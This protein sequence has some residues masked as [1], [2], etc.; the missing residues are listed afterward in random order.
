VVQSNGTVTE[1]L[2]N[3]GWYVAVGVPMGRWLDPA[4]SEARAGAMIRRG[5]Q[6]AIVEL[7]ALSVFLAALTPKRWSEL[8]TAAVEAGVEDP[9]ALVDSLQSDGLLIHFDEDEQ[10]NLEALRRLRLQPIGVG[11]GNDRNGD[12]GT[13]VIGDHKL[14]PL[15]NCDGLT[16]TVWAAS[17][18]RSLGDISDGLARGYSMPTEVVLR[19]ILHTL[20]ELLAARVAFLDAAPA[21]HS[22]E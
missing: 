17:D 2:V 21:R 10:E 3:A 14:I 4:D 16:Y 15:L 22:N 6:F 13:F 5:D 18:G 12:P 7:E 20:P 19:H 9:T 1:S 8:V 11:L